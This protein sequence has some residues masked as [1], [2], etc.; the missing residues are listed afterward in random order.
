MNV[1]TGLAILVSII[2][3]KTG[4]SMYQRARLTRAWETGLQAF[5]DGD[6]R[7]A[8]TAFS[9][10]VKWAPIWVLGRRMFARTLAALGR[11]AEAEEQFGFA[12]KLEPRNG[13]SYVDYAAYLASL[14]PDRED[15]AAEYLA[16]GLEH[17]PQLRQQIR[18]APGIGALWENERVRKSIEKIE[19]D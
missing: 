15:E 10:C 13:E 4:A 17:A 8:Q 9:R 14:G 18:Y 7:S 1:W 5:Q 19:S 6:L 12:I 3:A 2:V 11:H 16:Q